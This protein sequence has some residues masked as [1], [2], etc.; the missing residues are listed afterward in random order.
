MSTLV[1]WHVELEFTEE[2]N[3]TSAAALVRLGDGSEMR[4][5]GYAMR[6]P[7]DPEQLRVGEEIAGSRALMDLASQMLQKAHAE[8]DEVSGRHSYP[9]TQ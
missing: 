1:G 4:A 9:L 7:T 3:R 8:I 5:R 2:G 6:H